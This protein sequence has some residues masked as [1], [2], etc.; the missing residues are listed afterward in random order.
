MIKEKLS[1]FEIRTA[2][3][4]L[5]IINLYNA[6]QRTELGRVLGMQLLRS[7]TSVGA[8]VAEANQSRSTAEFVSKIAGARQE[9]QETLYWLYLI[10]RAKL[11]GTSRLPP[12]RQEAIEI[13]AILITMAARARKKLDKR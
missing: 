12:L 10:D 6:L 13:K 3:F 11:V 7:G 4:A 5:R 2:D 8:H 1:E 9:I